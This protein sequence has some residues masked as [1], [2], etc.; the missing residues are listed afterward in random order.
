MAIAIKISRAVVFPF[1]ST[2][3]HNHFPI[4]GNF[5]IVVFPFSSTSNHNNGRFFRPLIFV[6][7]PFS[8][9]SN[10]NFCW[11]AESFGVLYF[12]SLLHQTT[13]KRHGFVED[14]SCI[15]F[16]FYIKPQLTRRIMVRGRVVFPFSSTSNHNHYQDLKNYTK[17][18]FLSLLHQTTTDNTMPYLSDE[19][20]FLSLL[21][22]TT[23][24][25]EVLWEIIS[26]ISFL[27]YIK[28]QPVV[29]SPFCPP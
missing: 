29:Y 22:Q 13:T 7:F 11:V 19:L 28:P 5:L 16:L 26:C 8:S 20:Y 27:F 12:L 15:S 23:T 14:A 25:V 17:L 4:I 21:H 6:V 24:F 18:Y 2:S 9:T 1:S 10:H 3:N